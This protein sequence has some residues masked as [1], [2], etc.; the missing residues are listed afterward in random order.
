[1]VQA[2]DWADPWAPGGPTEADLIERVVGMLT[3]RPDAAARSAA[4]VALPAQPSKVEVCV[5]R[6]GIT[7]AAGKDVAVLLL[8]R[9]LT[10]P[11]TEWHQIAT[12][13][14]TG[15]AALDGL[16]DSGGALPADITIPADWELADTVVNVRRPTRDAR[17]S[18]STVVSFDV[19]FTGRSGIWLL[20][21]VVRHGTG[22][23][24][25]DLPTDLADLVRTS[26]QLAARTVEVVAPPAG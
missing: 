10:Q 26:P 24:V 4:S 19:D 14:L 21:A 16:P 23:P 13:A 8:L 17:P 11:P 12:P 3:P 25:L 15:L 1:V 2:G 20:L 18:E 6:R 9:Q 5:H 7:A 22:T